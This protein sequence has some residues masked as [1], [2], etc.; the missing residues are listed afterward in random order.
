MLAFAGYGAQRNA[1]RMS[2]HFHAGYL[3]RWRRGCSQGPAIRLL[4]SE[5]AVV[6]V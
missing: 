4:S 5:G 1:D 6:F 3:V 2:P